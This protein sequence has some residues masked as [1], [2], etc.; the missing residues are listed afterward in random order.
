MATNSLRVSLSCVVALLLTAPLAAQH[1]DRAAKVAAFN[2]ALETL[3]QAGPMVADLGAA[4]IKVPE[5]YRFVPKSNIKKFNDLNR[6]LTSPLEVGVIFPADFDWFVVLSYHDDGY[7]KDD[8]KTQL[9]QET[10]DAILAARREGTERSN[11]ERR[12]QKMAELTLRGWEKPPFYDDVTKN[13]TWGLQIQTKDSDD[14]NLNYESRILGRGGYM[15][16]NLVVGRQ[17]F[18]AALPV[19]NQLLAGF[20]YKDGQKYSEWKAGD[21]VAAVGLTGLVLGG[22]GVLAGK[23]GLFGKFFAVLAKGGKAII[24]V[25][26]AAIAGIVGLFKKMFGGGSS[27]ASNP[28]ESAATE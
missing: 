4:Q 9:D 12:K 28:D 13:L 16:A 23:A 26:V 14:Y 11:A 1:K 7:V 25:V 3:S 15:S 27:A 17:S 5:G 6:D 18:A 8:E 22:A 24:V 20:A 19:Y 21:K 10:I 2:K